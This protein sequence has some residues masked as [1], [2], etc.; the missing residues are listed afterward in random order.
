MGDEEI[1]TVTLFKDRPIYDAV[2]DK[3]KRKTMRKKINEKKKKRSIISNIF[4]F[5]KH[6]E[7]SPEVFDE[8]YKKYKLF[9]E[10]TDRPMLNRLFNDNETR[11]EFNKSYNE[12]VSDTSRSITKQVQ[13]NP[14]DDFYSYVNEEWLTSE[15]K[16]LKN[17]PKYYVEVD[18]F[19]IIQDKVYHELIEYT[20]KYISKNKDSTKANEIKNI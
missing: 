14:K 16:L 4:A 7:A 11:Q 20:K 15:N 12:L 18:D 10:A 1:K 9:A 2:F 8:F 6:Q 5:E 17:A 13:A 3:N 19:R